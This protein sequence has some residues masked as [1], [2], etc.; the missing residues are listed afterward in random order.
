E[1]ARI[2]Y[3]GYSEDTKLYIESYANG[4][5]QYIKEAGDN[6]PPEFKLLGYQ[7]R[8]WSEVDSL[9]IGKYMAY[10]L[11]GN[12]T[13]ELLYLNMAK[14]VDGDRLKEMLPGYPDRG[15][16]IM[17]EAWKAGNALK[18][19]NTPLPV[20]DINELGYYLPL[21]REGLGSNNWVLSGSMTKSGKPLL[22]NDM[23]L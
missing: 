19:S 16:T 10:T 8:P 7:P 17:K 3:P 1:A 21:P 15:L 14:K 2:S 6:L 18:G 5:N 23:H 11:G 20:M 4:V 12:M 22:C 9:S 13:A